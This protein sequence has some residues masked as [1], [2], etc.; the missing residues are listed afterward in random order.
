M[1]AGGPVIL[2]GIDGED[3]DH[4]PNS[5]YAQVV[6]S[7]YTQASNGGGGILVIGGL[8]SPADD[9]TIFWSQIAITNGVPIRFINGAADISSF[10]FAGFRMIAVVSDVE[11]TPSGG[12]TQEEHDALAARQAEIAAFVNNGGGLFG[13]SSDFADPYAYIAG[14]GSFTFNHPPMFDNIV[15]TPAGLAVG[16]TDLL[17]VCCW[18][19]EFATFP[20]FLSVLA[21]NAAT[22]QAVAVGGADVFIS[23]IA[24]SP[25][26]AN[27]SQCQGV[28]LTATVTENGAPVNGTAVT[29]ASPSGPLATVPTNASGVATY[30]VTAGSPGTVTITASYID[31]RGHTQ[32]SSPATITFFADADCDTVPDSTDNCPLT[33]NTDQ[34]DTDGDG[35]GDACDNCRSTANPNQADSDGDGVGD[36]CDNC[37]TTANPDQADT[38]H[39]GVGDACDNCRTIPNPAQAD[40]D[41]DGVGDACTPY[42]PADGGFFVVGNLVDLA[43]NATVNFWGSQWSSNNLLSGGAAPNSMKGFVSSTGL[44][45]CGSTYTTRP[46]NSSGPPATIP[47]FMPVV[48]S[49]NITKSGPTIS[50][51]VKAIYIVETRAGYAGNPGHPGM[52][53]VVAMICGTP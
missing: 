52:G 18:H 11:N 51:D 44:P 21:T 24:L 49:S 4:G 34:A 45:A 38:D 20:S 3:L 5:T 47:R 19:Q 6:N 37:L 15:P 9:V 16:I 8:K 10:S 13:L 33:P 12:L 35:I 43:G 50:G 53:R 48:V 23:A 28:T 17:D 7:V 14:L 46:G 1:S 25:E 29:F 32:T 30:T 22:G 42:T 39:D 2:M 31:S 26:S 27:A 40:L 36:A 41:G